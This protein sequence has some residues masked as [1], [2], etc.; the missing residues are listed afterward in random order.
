ME[1]SFGIQT[2]SLA[3]GAAVRKD[4]RCSVSS[5]ASELWSRPDNNSSDMAYSLSYALEKSLKLWQVKEMS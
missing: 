3:V 4:Q 5:S 2:R 1:A